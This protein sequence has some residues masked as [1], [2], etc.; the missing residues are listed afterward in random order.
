M[1]LLRL[2]SP[3]PV[4]KR[5]L[6]RRVRDRHL[7]ASC[8]SCKPR[9]AWSGRGSPPA[10]GDPVGCGVRSGRSSGP[11]RRHG[12]VNGTGST[13]RARA[14]AAGACS[15][16]PRFRPARR[17]RPWS[18][19]EIRAPGEAGALRRPSRHRRGDASALRRRLAAAIPSRVLA[20]HGR[21]GPARADRA[22]R[23]RHRRRSSRPSSSATE[24]DP[25]LERRGSMSA[26]ETAKP[27]QSSGSCRSPRLF[28]RCSGRSVPAAV[29]PAKLHGSRGWR[30]REAASS[31]STA[32]RG[33][34][35]A[36]RYVG[37]RS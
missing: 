28:T 5:H 25:S 2:T 17:R 9:P 37:N 21:A 24:S 23:S 3:K 26:R 18:S 11:R 12:I 6:G 20:V 22:C 31:R 8:P 30:F 1:L 35:Q 10:P 33:C 14:S 13:S 27:L 19:A 7:F 15:S 34:A 36:R 16:S 29:S 4:V 32:G